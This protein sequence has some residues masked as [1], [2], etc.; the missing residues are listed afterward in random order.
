M[1]PPRQQEEGPHA[2]LLEE[3]GDNPSERLFAWCVGLLRRHVRERNQSPR[4]FGIDGDEPDHVYVYEHPEDGD[5][6]AGEGVGCEQ[7]GQ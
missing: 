3:R 5:A 1:E 6:A 2:F 4:F 7:L